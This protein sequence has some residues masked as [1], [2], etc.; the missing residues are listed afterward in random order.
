KIV[1]AIAMRAWK[2]KNDFKILILNDKKIC[3]LLGSEK[4]EEI[5][6]VNYH[7]KYISAT[8]NRVF[9]DS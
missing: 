7:L 3:S 6:D 8:F 4:I 9:V 5:F 2:D 1:Q